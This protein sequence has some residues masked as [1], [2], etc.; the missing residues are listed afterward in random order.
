MVAFSKRNI[1]YDL[2]SVVEATS[3]LSFHGFTP[4]KRNTV[5]VSLGLFQEKFCLCS[6]FS[7]LT[8]SFSFVWQLLIY[9]SIPSR[10]PMNCPCLPRYSHGPLHHS[11]WV[12]GFVLRDCSDTHIHWVT[13]LHLNLQRIWGIFLLPDHSLVLMLK[14]FLQA[15]FLY[16][17]LCQ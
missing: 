10:T 1:D 5:S 7:I 12:S 16:N 11:N 2:S 17:V 15:V 9:K 4:P 6:H 14:T 3:D 13:N 8:K